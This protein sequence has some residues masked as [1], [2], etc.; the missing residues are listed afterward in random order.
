MKY[1][2]KKFDK[3]DSA[4][5]GWMSEHGLKLLRLSIGFIFIWYGAVKFFPGISPAEDLAIR[6]IQAISFNLISEK[7]III[8]LALW[9]LLIGI[10]LVLRIFLRET[11]LLLFLQMIGTFFPIFLFPSEVFNIFPYS[12]T[13]EGQYIIKNIVIVSSGIVIGATARGS[14][15]KAN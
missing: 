7:T 15:I 5:T 6:T 13:I 11:L 9:E 4:I 10:G 12:L 14:K 3:I 1:R 8:T 2:G